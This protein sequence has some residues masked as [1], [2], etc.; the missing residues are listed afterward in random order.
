MID[1]HS[2][3]SSHLAKLTYN[4]HNQTY[5]ACCPICREGNSWLKR[6]RFY[7]YNKTN[8]CYCFNCGYNAKLFKLYYDLTGKPASQTLFTNEKLKEKEIEIEK[9]PEILP[10]DSVNIFES[11]QIFKNMGN[12]IFK[13]CLHYLTERGLHRAINKPKT[14]WFSSS[15]YVHKNR[16]IIPFYDLDGKIVYYQS[17]KLPFDKSNTPNYLSKNGGDRSLFNAD[18]IT[19]YPYIFIFE[20][21]LDACFCRNGVAVSGINKSRSNLTDK[22]EEQLNNFP[23]HTKIWV[24]DN[25]DMDETAR[26]KIKQLADSGQ[27][28]FVWPKN[29]PYKDFN[30]MCVDKNINQIETDFIIKNSFSGPKAKMII[31]RFCC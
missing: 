29:L 17:R 15:D 11:T 31:S 20:G 9:P 14:F 3:L 1:V 22:Q 23:L 19:E 24:L 6:K 8:S 30:E 21:P 18:K 13:G 10:K 12:P 16:L 28:V 27:K 4:K 5:I 2:F 26:K 25:Q 7:F